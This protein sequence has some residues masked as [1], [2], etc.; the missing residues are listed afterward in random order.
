MLLECKLWLKTTL[1]LIIGQIIDEE[2]KRA[3][4]V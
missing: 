3:R 2:K 4:R 1:G